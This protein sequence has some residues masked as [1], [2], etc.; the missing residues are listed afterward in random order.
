MSYAEQVARQLRMI[1]AGEK[2]SGR[3]LAKKINTCAV[4]VS[5]WRS[6]GIIRT[7]KFGE[8]LSALDMTVIE[9]FSYGEEKK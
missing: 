5:N 8:L 3:A 9:F 6:S 7:K 1:M 4:S 2:I